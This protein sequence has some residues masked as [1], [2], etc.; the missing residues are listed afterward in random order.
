MVEEAAAEHAHGVRQG[1][2]M[3]HFALP[4]AVGLVI[5]VEAVMVEFLRPALLD[6]G[7]C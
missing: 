3:D 7:A 5:I 6:F 2:I 1:R 4:R